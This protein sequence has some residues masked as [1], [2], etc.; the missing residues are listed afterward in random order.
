V[1]LSGNIQATKVFFN[2]SLFNDSA[3]PVLTSRVS[4]IAFDTTANIISS[5]PNA[6]TGVFGSVRYNANQPNGI[7]NTEVCFTAFNC[8]GGGNGGVTLG[9]TGVGTATLYFSGNITSLSFDDIYVRYQS[10][11]CRSGSTCASSASGIGTVV[12][13]TPM[14]P[15]VPEPSTYALMGTGLFAL[16][17]AGRRRATAK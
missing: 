17:V 5:A 13:N 4:N 1:V 16:A 9:N 7:G 3:S 12:P 15:E 10:V 6:V 8:P 14:P 11:T 2:Y